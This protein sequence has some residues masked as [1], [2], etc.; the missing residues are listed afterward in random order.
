MKL[1][2]VTVF[3]CLILIGSIEAI[4]TPQNSLKVTYIG[5]TGF[6]VQCQGHKVAIDAILGGWKSTDFDIPSD[7]TVNLMTTSQP[8]FDNINVI[9]ITHSHSDHFEASIV[10]KYLKNNSTCIVLCS[11]Q[12]ADKLAAQPEYAEVRERIHT[13][14][15][16]VDSVTMFNQDGISVRILTSKHSPYFVTDS[17]GQKVDRHRNIEH[18]EYLF[19]IE[20][21]SFLH[22][23]DAAILDTEKYSRI[24]LGKDSIDVAFVQRWGCNDIMFMNEKIVREFMLPRNIF[25]THLPPGKGIQLTMDPVCKNHRDVK[26]PTRSLQSWV[27]R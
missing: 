2:K 1:I 21:R 22:T 8:P 5:N 10:A 18:L 13:I 24:G 17:T 26:I 4:S 3:L 25:F 6:L 12:V 11:P 27:V 23:G 15:A 20:G 14:N 16:P 9:A 19:T 7:S